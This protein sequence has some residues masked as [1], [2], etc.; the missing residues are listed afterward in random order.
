[1]PILIFLRFYVFELWTRTGRQ[2]DRQTD[3]RTRRIMWPKWRTHEKLGVVCIT[4]VAYVNHN[5][6]IQMVCF[7]MNCC[8]IWQ[9]R[10]SISFITSFKFNLDV[11]HQSNKKITYGR[12][13]MPQWRLTANAALHDWFSWPV[14]WTDHITLLLTLAQAEYCSIAAAAAAATFERLIVDHRVM[15]VE[16]YC[17]WPN[18]CCWRT[19]RLRGEFSSA[20]SYRWCLI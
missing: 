4:H 18:H 16:L 12:V 10:F 1:M 9:L 5:N 19:R 15:R 14:I 7:S 20:P 17:C 8:T 11:D 2:T 3:R 13:C 6:V